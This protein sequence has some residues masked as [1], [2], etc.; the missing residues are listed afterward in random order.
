M[1]YQ[2]LPVSRDEATGS[3]DLLEHPGKG[4]RRVFPCHVTQYVGCIRLYPLGFSNDHEAMTSKDWERNLKPDSPTKSQWHS[5]VEVFGG[6]NQLMAVFMYNATFC[7]CLIG[8]DLGDDS[9][10]ENDPT[11]LFTPPATWII[12]GS[13]VT[14]GRGIDNRL[15]QCTREHPEKACYLYIY[16]YIYIYGTIYIY[17]LAI[18]CDLFGIVVDDLVKG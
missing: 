10:K 18:H 6:Q 7:W 9:C 17:I 11:L 14:S 1:L 15:R 3:C 4:F 2:I 12:S 8:S 16:I 13:T 5:N